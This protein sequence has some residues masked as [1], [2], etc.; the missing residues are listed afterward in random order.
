MHPLADRKT[1]MASSIAPV[2]AAP[3]AQ[4]ALVTNVLGPCTRFTDSANFTVLSA[5][6]GVLFRRFQTS[7]TDEEKPR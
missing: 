4:A 5:D 1:P 2:L 7:I 6:G 3:N